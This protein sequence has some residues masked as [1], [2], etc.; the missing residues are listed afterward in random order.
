[1]IDRVRHIGNMSSGNFGTEIGRQIFLHEKGKTA[2]LTFLKA[3]NSKSPFA[4]TVNWAELS[5]HANFRRLF[6]A[7]T[8][9]TKTITQNLSTR[10]MTITK[11]CWYPYCKECDGM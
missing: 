8:M 4:S 2:N 1:M 11:T 9:V 10:P 7:F 5:S 3:E 6:N